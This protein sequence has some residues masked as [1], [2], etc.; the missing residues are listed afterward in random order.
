MFKN[1][2]LMLRGDLSEQRS[3]AKEPKGKTNK[4]ASIGLKATE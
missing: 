3:G 4:Q 1:D 2:Y